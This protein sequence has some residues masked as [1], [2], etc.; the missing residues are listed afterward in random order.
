M[1]AIVPPP[2]SNVH[3]CGNVCICSLTL[4][5]LFMLEITLRLNARPHRSVIVPLPSN[6]HIFSVHFCGRC[7][8]TFDCTCVMVFCV[9]FNRNDDRDLFASRY[10]ITS[11]ISSN[12]N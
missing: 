5:V 7:F 6:E 12:I 8:Y 4:A 10:R 9:G 11:I 2:S 1:Y 3:F